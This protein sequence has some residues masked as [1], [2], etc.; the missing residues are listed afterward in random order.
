MVFPLPSTTATVA[1]CAPPGASTG[2]VAVIASAGGISALFKLLAGLPASFP[3]P[4]LVSQHLSRTAPSLL[5]ELLARRSALRV[6]WARFGH[7]PRP[8]TVYLAEPGYQLEAST[9]G[10]VVTR[11]APRASAWLAAADALLESV[12]ATYGSKS[13]GIVMSGMIAAGTR[14]VRAIRAQGGIALAESEASA[15]Y[16]SMPMAAIDLGK[17]DI[18]CSATRIAEA[19]IAFTEFQAWSESEGGAG[20]A[21]GV[22]PGPPPISASRIS[23][24][25]RRGRA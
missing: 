19:L 1:S 23:T 20:V 15:G 7:M 2:A 17:A 6:E 5:A 3:L 24:S 10:F 13:V 8:G 18:V 12:A 4:V 16:F 14:G 11:L 22:P 21:A 9:S 25:S